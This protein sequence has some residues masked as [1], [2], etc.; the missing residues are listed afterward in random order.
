MGK[1]RGKLRGRGDEGKENSW[2]LTE[3]GRVG[4]TVKKSHEDE[5]LDSER[6]R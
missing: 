4:K 5:S 1:K 6:Q 3:R 2:V